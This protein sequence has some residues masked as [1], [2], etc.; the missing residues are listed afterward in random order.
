MRS[1]CSVELRPRYIQN[2][3]STYRTHGASPEG[4]RG[5]LGMGG[6]DQGKGRNRLD[7]IRR[8]STCEAPWDRRPKGAAMGGWSRV[9]PAPRDR[10]N[11]RRPPAVSREMVASGAAGCSKR[12]PYLHPG[13]LLEAL[14]HGTGPGRP[15]LAD[16]CRSTLRGQLAERAEGGE[17][18]Q[19]AGTDRRT[20]GQPKRRRQ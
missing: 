17:A 16:G 10:A 3:R 13:P 4:T 7:F 19:T 14:T 5:L 6:K 12:A 8:N 1:D 20:G 11:H 2:H 18:D 15:S 9:Y